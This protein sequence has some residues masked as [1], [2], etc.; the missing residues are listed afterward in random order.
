MVFSVANGY[1]FTLFYEHIK[2]WIDV[3]FFIKN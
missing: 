2:P 1:I 3:K